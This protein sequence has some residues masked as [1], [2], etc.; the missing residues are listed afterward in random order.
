M[1]TQL[2]GYSRHLAS[3]AGCPSSPQN[4]RVASHPMEEGLGPS[5]SIIYS[6]LLCSI[7]QELSIYKLRTVFSCVCLFILCWLRI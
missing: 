2:A 4:L 1:D 6:V 5:T 3:G 7:K